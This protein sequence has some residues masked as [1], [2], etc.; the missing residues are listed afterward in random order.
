MSVRNNLSLGL[1]SWMAMIGD[2]HNRLTAKEFL[3]KLR[4]SLHEGR[5]E[6]LHRQDKPVA[7]LIWRRPTR[8]SWA[9]LLALH[10][11]THTEAQTLDSQVWLDFWVRPLGCDVELALMVRDCMASHGI[12]DVTL[13]WHDPSTNEG[14]GKLHL[15]I[16]IDAMKGM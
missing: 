6:I 2:T 10:G 7:W 11:D 5:L 15:N 8:Q 12:S 3:S 13:S 9:Q 1:L 4:S 16:P 14:A